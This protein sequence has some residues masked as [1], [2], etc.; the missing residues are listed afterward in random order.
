MGDGLLCGVVERFV[1]V[2]VGG[3]GGCEV[4]GG[5]YTG[6][7]GAMGVGGVYTGCWAMGVCGVGPIGLFVIP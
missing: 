2:V 4:L 3:G 5:E 1:V 7:C 6:G